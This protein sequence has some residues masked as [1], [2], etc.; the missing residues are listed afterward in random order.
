MKVDAIVNSA[1]PE[2][3]IGGGV[4]GKIYEKAGQEQLLEKR[5]KIGI[6]EV[7]EAA[8]TPAFGID[9]KYII[10]TVGPVWKD[11]N[12][13][14]RNLLYACYENVLHIADTLQCKSIA[15]PL[16]ST[17]VYNFPKDEALQ[18]AISAI[19]KF[20]L[21]HEMNISLVVY[22]R[23]SFLLSGKLFQDV[24]TYIDENYVKQEKAK[25]HYSRDIASG[26]RKFEK[27]ENQSGNSPDGLVESVLE[28]REC[29]VYEE[30][31]YAEPIQRKNRS[32][33]EVI[34]Q[35]SDTFSQ[36]LFR[37]IDEKGKTDVEIYKKANMDR[38]LF[39]KIRNNVEYKP[40][41]KTA[42][43]LAIALEL[44]LDETKDF[45]ARAGFALSPSSKFDLIVEFFIEN[46]IYDVYTINLTLFE[47]RQSILGE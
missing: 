14:E 33:E 9:A 10:H 35:L 22:D 4:E 7:G 3:C 5:K 31:S 30:C 45:L 11:G 28:P 6:I 12:S 44:N 36:T 26:K 24:T 41:K 43:A 25:R 21:Y 42:I 29:E 37:L 8:V 39:S 34:G 27:K 32:L 18:I 40:S 23:A 17:G 20:L 1:N 13:G 46:H 19:S 47:H 38:K 2:P 16:I 15:F